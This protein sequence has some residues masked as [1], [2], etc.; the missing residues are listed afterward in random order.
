MSLRFYPI[1]VKQ[2]NRETADCVSLELDIPSDLQETFRFREGQ[3][4]TLRVNLFGEEVRRTYSLCSSPLEN[5]WK[6]AVKRVKGGAFSTYANEELKSGDVLDVMPPVGMFNCPL[7]PSA[8]RN[9]L[10]FAAGSGITPVLSIIKTV[11]ATEPLSRFTLVYGNRNRS[12]IIFLEELENLKNKFLNRFNLVHILSREK[13][14][15][16]LHFGRINTAKLEELSPLLHYDTVD[17]CFVCGPE[18]MIFAVRDFLEKEGLD[19]K[20]IHFELFTSPG[21]KKAVTEEEDS[22]L[23]TGP[24]SKISVRLDGRQFDF[25]LSLQSPATLLDAALRQ[26]A[27]L[28][29]ACKGGMCCTC[30]A[31]LVEGEVM[32]DVHWGLDEE[33]VEKGYILTCQAHPKTEKVVIDFDAK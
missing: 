31:K 17:E 18:E 21:Q 32:M 6:V 8:A 11:L 22:W 27:D 30:K 9:Y 14:D 7:N 10:A 1:A 24:V 20:K 15:T 4:L 19:K 16:P 5:T 33:E 3:S 13:T 2:V 12:S 28:P 25:D 29:F 23:I 26:G